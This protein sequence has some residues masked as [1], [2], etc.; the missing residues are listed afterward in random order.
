MKLKNQLFK[1]NDIMPTAD[2]MV[3]CVRLLSDSI[4]YKAHF[5]GEPVTPGVCIMQMAKELI[6]ARMEREYEITDIKNVKFL[7]ILSPIESPEVTFTFSKMVVD[8]TTVTA[9][10]DVNNDSHLFSSIS[11]TCKAKC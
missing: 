5:P 1:I 2:G 10:V 11:F 7:Y 9:K 8:E 3:C 6:E 4:I